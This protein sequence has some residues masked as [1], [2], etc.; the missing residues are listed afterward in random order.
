MCTTKTAM[1]NA[2]IFGASVASVAVA[3]HGAKRRC[4]CALAAQRCAFM[5]GRSPR[6]S[7]VKV[8]ATFLI[9]R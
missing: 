5:S 4:C 2:G 9:E 1:L 6:T 3:F 8:A 7:D